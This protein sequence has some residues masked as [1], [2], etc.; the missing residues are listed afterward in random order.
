L[1]TMKSL[2]NLV[3]WQSTLAYLKKPPKGYPNEA[4]DILAGLDDISGKVENGTYNNEYDFENDI[5]LL[6][7][8]AYDGHLTFTGMAFG[9]VF[10]WLRNRTIALVSGSSDGKETPK[11][12]SVSDLNTT[13]NEMPPAISQIDG[14]DAAEFIKEESRNM[15]YHDPDT[16]YNNMFYMQPAE[17]YGSFANPRFYP[18]PSVNITYEDGSSKVFKNMASVRSPA[19]WSGVRDGESFYNTFIVPS[20]DS[21]KV[22]KRA[23]DHREPRNISP[24]RDPELI[25]RGVPF[26]Y[27]EPVVQ[28]SADDVKLAGFYMDT[29]NGKFGILV[30]QTFSVADE[31]SPS[32]TIA[33]IEE[34]QQVVQEYISRSKA[35]GVQK[36]IIDL[37]NNGGGLIMLGYDLFLQFFPSMKP[38][39][40]S[41]WRAHQGSELISNMTSSYSS[42]SRSNPF[43]YTSPFSRFSY[44][45]S[46]EKDFSSVEDMYSSPEFNGDK[47]TALLRYNLS[48]PLITSS[49][50][51]GVGIDMTGYGSRSNFTEDPFKA[52]DLIILSDGICAS[53][54]ALFTELMV[55]QANVKTLAVGG[56]P[57]LGPMQPVGGTKGSMLLRSDSIILVT[58]M[59]VSSFARGSE[60]NEWRDFL[61]S[62][63]SIGIVNAGVNFQDNIRKGLEEDGIPT[64]FL[65][66]TASCRIW[67]EPKMYLN[68]SALWEKTAQ[69]AF[70]RDGGMDEEACLAGSVTSKEAQTGQGDGNP[71]TGGG[72]GTG[73]GD[74]PAPSSSQS[75]GA[76]AGAVQPIEGCWS[77]IFVC[78]FVAFLSMAFGASL[79]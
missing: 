37:R 20:V 8:K 77:A 56:L 29:S 76:A 63:F 59:V 61:P 3:Q 36:H 38:Q 44:L 12:W 34:F 42:F 47:F 19:A 26:A 49:I 70:G 71:Q 21:F 39:L 1:S 48:N 15:W 64:Q 55:Q 4:V 9:G 66:D 52:E 75:K 13:S 67:Y 11:I 16:R 58:D 46:E 31:Q 5:S 22:K 78:G 53:T 74:G 73:T 28:H 23:I 41:R 6:L 24:K 14:K 35:E 25:R 68:V 69:V 27:P 62:N 2:K 57:H 72:P 7:I 17:S 65:N 45:N 18:G 54:C 50:R 51:W 60:E 43:L 40:L 10:Q 32:G 30:V 79:I 33:G